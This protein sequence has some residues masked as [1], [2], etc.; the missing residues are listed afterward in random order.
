[1]HTH[2]LRDW[3]FL[4]E[5]NDTVWNETSIIVVVVI[6]AGAHGFFIGL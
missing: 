4:P 5:S 2:I 6:G 3:Q 1:M